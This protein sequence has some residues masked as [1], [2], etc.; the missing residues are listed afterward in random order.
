MSD[1]KPL[2]GASFGNSTSLGAKL[3][4]IE[5][6]RTDL[7][8]ENFQVPGIVVCGEQSAGKSSVIEAITG[9]DF[10]RGENTCTRCPAI[11]RLESVPDCGT[12]FAL[13]S[14]NPTFE[15]D[16]TRLDDLTGIA[17]EIQRRQTPST[18]DEA[19]HV[20][21][22]DEP[23]HIKITR[24]SGPS[25]TLIDLPGVAHLYSAPSGVVVP[26][27][28]DIHKETSGM[29]K[30][31]INNPE[32]IVLAVI[33]ANNDFHNTE[34]L[35]YCRESDATGERTLGVV[36]KVDM[37]PH[38]SNILGKMRMEGDHGVLLKLGFIAVR[39]RTPQETSESLSLSEV[40]NRER[41]LFRSHPLL[42]QLSEDMWGTTTLIEQICVI[43]EK[44]V[45]KFLSEI[46]PRIQDR[47]E[48]VRDD[49]KRLP[50]RCDTH[51]RRFN[52]LS[53][54]LN[55]VVH[56]L[57]KLN[58]GRSASEVLA[59]L[60]CDQE[61]DR[62]RVSFQMAE[63]ARE[64]GELLSARLPDFLHSETIA[65]ELRQEMQYLRGHQLANFL[66]HDTFFLTLGASFDKVVKDCSARL[67]ANVF[68]MMTD[69]IST[70][71]QETHIC[72]SYADLGPAIL[73]GPIDG[74]LRKAKE[75][76]EGAVKLFLDCET[77]W[78]FTT[79]HYYADTMAK[80]H[81]QFAR[82][83][84]SGHDGD[85]SDEKVEEVEDTPEDEIPQSFFRALKGKLMSNEEQGLWEMQLSLHVYTKVRN[86]RVFDTVPMLVRQ[87]LVKELIQGLADAVTSW[88]LSD[89]GGRLEMAMAEGADVVRRS[90]M[91]H[92]SEE[93]LISVLGKLGSVVGGGGSRT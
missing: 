36:T 93:R 56:T 7:Q 60:A 27:S 41:A 55:D 74:F 78:V 40:Q 89:E 88:F 26:E 66:S 11:V 32:M 3:G 65:A 91:L 54:A 31:Y 46:N 52:E 34:V 4:L 5:Q 24:S 63:F 86:K 58:S 28:F 42:K 50:R 80:C 62:L 77:N 9:I 48:R 68:N 69:A 70:V 45:N 81:E 87:V 12:P 39:N 49:I 47:L 84:T 76:V 64:F 22:F 6:I 23:I 57:E 75:K 83:M 30:K 19:E 59:P 29:V 67:I 82:R 13:V 14:S 37:V 51:V 10:P 38:D 17:E 16:T 92:R 35:K 79:N 53:L 43:Q 72:R 90:K 44:R 1:G 85:G 2:F 8:A 33:P 61:G 20:P 71:V 25:L 18:S 73:N 15:T 21:I